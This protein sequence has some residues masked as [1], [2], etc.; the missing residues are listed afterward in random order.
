[1]LLQS[2]YDT[3][4][5]LSTHGLEQHFDLAKDDQVKEQEE[6]SQLLPGSR[7]MAPIHQLSLRSP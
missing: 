5:T 2:P 3:I 7:L 4:F 1:M 6:R